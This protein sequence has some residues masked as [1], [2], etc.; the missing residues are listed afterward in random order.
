MKMQRLER[1]FPFEL[2]IAIAEADGVCPGGHD[3]WSG[4]A[5]SAVCCTWAVPGARLSVGELVGTVAGS[6]GRP[7]TAAADPRPAAF[8]HIRSHCT[9][10]PSDNGAGWR[11]GVNGSGIDWWK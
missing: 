9:L 3:P 4:C 6:H 10:V 7:G 11:E 8:T 1:I 5:N 2:S